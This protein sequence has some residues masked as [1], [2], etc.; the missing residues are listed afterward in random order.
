MGP[1]NYEFI[2]HSSFCRVV[3]ILEIAECSEDLILKYQFYNLCK[4]TDII[5]SAFKD[6]IARPFSYKIPQNFLLTDHS[7]DKTL[8]IFSLK[9][10]SLANTQGPLYSSIFNLGS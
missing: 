4:K 8:E 1:S 3:F 9:T 5:I 7:N 6:F 2:I 10:V